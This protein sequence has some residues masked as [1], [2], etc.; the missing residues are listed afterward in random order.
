MNRGNLT[1]EQA[2]RYPKAKVKWQLNDD[3]EYTTFDNITSALLY[4]AESYGEYQSTAMVYALDYISDCKL[5]LRSF[6][7]LTEDEKGALNNLLVAE[8]FP[9]IKFSSNGLLTDD[10]NENILAKIKKMSLV[11]DYLRF[12]NIYL[13]DLPDGTY[14]LDEGKAVAEWT[15]KSKTNWKK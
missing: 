4:W 6:K 14:T 1:I 11:S 12:I 15:Q 3:F 8:N 5:Q 13:R 10:S 9:R 7:S 2:M